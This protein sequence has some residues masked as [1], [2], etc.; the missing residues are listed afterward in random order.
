MD[1]YYYFCVI[2]TYMSSSLFLAAAVSHGTYGWWEMFFFIIT[3]VRVIIS[4]HSF[5]QLVFCG[6]Q[7]PIKCAT[8]GSD[9]SS[10]PLS[11][12]ISG[13]S[14]LEYT[15]KGVKILLSLYFQIEST[16]SAHKQR[17]QHTGKAVQMTTSFF[18]NSI[19]YYTHFPFFFPITSWWL[20][21][22]FYYFLYGWWGGGL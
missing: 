16:V 21:Y 12:A 15:K 4:W 20:F 17:S 8:S 19:S 22:W 1:Y 13:N 2:H 3:S 18:I 9:S 10:L 6:A 14:L 5:R 11:T 7:V